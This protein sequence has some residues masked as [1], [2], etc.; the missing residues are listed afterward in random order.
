MS[1]W[2][3]PRLHLHRREL[4]V[5]VPPSSLT[6]ARRE[7]DVARTAR[8][9]LVLLLVLL[10]HGRVAVVL[11]RRA[12]VA[13]VRRQLGAAVRL[14]RRRQLRRGG[15]VAVR[16]VALRV[17]HGLAV[18]LLAHLEV[19]R[20]ALEHLLEL[21]VEPRHE[22]VLGEV[23]V[24]HELAAGAA[25]LRLVLEALLHEVELVLGVG[26]EALLQR[27]RALHH[28]GYLDAHEEGVGLED[29]EQLGGQLAEAAHDVEELVDVALA[30]E[31][32]CAARHLR[33]HAADR[34]HVHGLAVLR[35][36]RQQLRPAVPARGHVVGVARA[37][38]S[39]RARKAKVTQ[40]QRA[41]QWCGAAEAVRTGGRAGGRRCGA[42]HRRGGGRGGGGGGCQELHRCAR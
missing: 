18:L 25:V 30:R 26:G 12:A 32:G 17:A 5:K 10:V 15:R 8:H 16:V 29:L 31:E 42:G 40:L 3:E 24:L 7:L 27:L 13:V 23:G 6:V 34:P 38:A 20:V 11:V 33:Q 28:L 2:F 9:V 21:A 1:A 37:G 4:V 35:V 14:V 19:L 22:A 36:S 41:C 39:E